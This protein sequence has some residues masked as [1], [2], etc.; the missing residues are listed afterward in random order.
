M[1]DRDRAAIDVDPLGIPAELL[2]DGERLRGERFVGLDQVEILE[3]PAGLGQRLAAG[4]DRAD[5]HDRGIDAGRGEALDARQ[6]R[7][8]AALGLLARGDDQGGGTVVEARGV[9][10]G[11]RTVLLEGRTQPGEAG[12]EHALT[13]EL[14]LVDDRVA[15]AALDRDRRDLAVEPAFAPRR[16]GL[17]LAGGSEF[18][19]RVAADLI[20][21]GQIFGGDAHVIAVEDVRQAVLDHDVDQLDRTHLLAGAQR[22]GV[23]GERHILLAAGDDQLGVA[24]QDRLGG[25]HHRAQAR[26]AHLLHAPGRDLLGH[27]GSHRGLAGRVLALRGGEHLAQ[28]H[29]VHLLGLHAGLLERGDDRDAAELMGGRCRIGTEKAADGGALGGGDDDLGHGRMLLLQI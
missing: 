17:V 14:V 23:R 19:L 29:F 26:S 12:D 1:A 2:A 25:H 21:L 24:R 16:L 18:V 27:A 15:L 8:A 3:L 10:G 5:A 4:G 13:D 6:D 20:L 11:D 9:G 22:L 7:R 28:D